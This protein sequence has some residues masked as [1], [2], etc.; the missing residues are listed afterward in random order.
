M[1]K[2]KAEIGN[3]RNW[4][5]ERLARLLGGQKKRIEKVGETKKGPLREGDLKRGLD[6]A[7]SATTG[8][9]DLRGE[10]VARRTGVDLKI[11]KKTK[12]REIGGRSGRGL[13]GAIKDSRS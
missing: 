8:Q 5:G 11:T 6:L 12:E 1:R 3:R 10:S 9:S 2:K 4:G 7:N 13:G